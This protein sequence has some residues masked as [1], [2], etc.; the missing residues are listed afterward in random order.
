MNNNRKIIE[1][2]IL[3]EA[4]KLAKLQANNTVIFVSGHG[5]HPGVIGIVAGR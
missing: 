5:W 2:T 4:H 1:L 3:E